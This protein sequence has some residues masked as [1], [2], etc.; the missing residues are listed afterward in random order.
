MAEHLSKLLLT[1]ALNVC[2]GKE[3]LDF[4]VFIAF[5]RRL[6]TAANGDYENLHQNKKFSPI[7]MMAPYNFMY[8]QN[9]VRRMR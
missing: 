5:G 6:K 9:L 1:T 2:N 8:P 4:N 3:E 7:P